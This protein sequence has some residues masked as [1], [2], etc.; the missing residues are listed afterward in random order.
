MWR[1][2]INTWKKLKKE[3]D[4]ILMEWTLAALFAGS[5]LLLIISFFKAR[6]ASKAEQ[7]ELD[8]MHIATMNEIKELKD[9]IQK[10]EHD[11][12][13]VINE[14]G[15]QLT[16]QERR[17]MREV[18]DLYKRKYS[19]ENIAAKKQVTENEIK[20]ILAPYITSKN[21]RSKFAHEA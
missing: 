6:K 21:E 13:I 3:R 15:I 20:Q 12:D 10:I 11:V 7:R 2:I 1:G 9:S 14:S 5:A 18:I 8:M 16:P 19:I 4:P 17:F